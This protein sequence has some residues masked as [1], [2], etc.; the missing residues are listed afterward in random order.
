MRCFP[1]NRRSAQRALDRERREKHRQ[2]EEERE[3]VRQQLREKYNLNKPTSIDEPEEEDQS[4]SSS[5]SEG[6]SDGEE[7]EEDEDEEK[8]AQEERMEKL[9]SES[10]FN[11]P[12]MLTRLTLGKLAVLVSSLVT[13]LFSMYLLVSFVHLKIK[14]SVSNMR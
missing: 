5:A 14:A 7:E 13:G 11:C 2:L 3:A 4:D 1:L 8:L 12:D 6:E 10:R 9:A